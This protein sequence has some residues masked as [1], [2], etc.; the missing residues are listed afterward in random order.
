MANGYLGSSNT[1]TW[2]SGTAQLYMKIAELGLPAETVADMG[3]KAA[4]KVIGAIHDPYYDMW[5][6]CDDEAKRQWLLFIIFGIHP[7]HVEW[8]RQRPFATVDEWLGEE[9]AKYRRAIGF[10]DPNPAFMRAW[11]MFQQEHKDRSLAA[12]E[13]D[14]KSAPVADLP[15]SRRKR[16]GRA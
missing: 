1:A 12:I 4:A 5:H 7:D 16:G 2:Q 11:A 13:A 8:L 9:G 15:M 10:R 6:G 3:L 14:V